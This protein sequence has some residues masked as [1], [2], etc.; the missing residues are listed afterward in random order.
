MTKRV[1]E[2]NSRRTVSPGKGRVNRLVQGVLLAAMLL[3]LPLL[4]LAVIG[5]PISPYLQF[6]PETRLVDQPPFS[7]PFFALIAMLLFALVVPFLVWCILSAPSRVSFKRGWRPFPWWGSVGLALTGVAWVL[8]W[9]RFDWFA[10]GQ[11][12]IFPGLWFGFILVINGLTFMRS[13]RCMLL[14]QPARFGLL[15]PVSAV[16]WW[17]FEYLNRF[18]QNWAYLQVD[19]FSPLEYVIYASISF[20]TV[21]PA[22]L[23]TRDFLATFPF[24]DRFFNDVLPIQPARPEVL[25]VGLLCLSGAGL[26]LIG[27]WPNVLFPLVWVAPLVIIVTSQTLLGEGHVLSSV[28]TGNWRPVVTAALAALICGFFWEMWNFY[29]LTKWVYS[30]PYVQRFH[31]FEMPIL[32]YGGYLPFGLECAIIGEWVL[33]RKRR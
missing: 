7:W 29:S 18:V 16:F 12:F 8:S 2:F 33:G 28:T 17:F 32:G 9:N 14:D 1:A 24:F 10:W 5:Q 27:V 19:H 26:A 22:V 3:G 23:G 25:S 21:L 11:P 31:V 13:G 20:S 6:P 4:G 15:F 30:I